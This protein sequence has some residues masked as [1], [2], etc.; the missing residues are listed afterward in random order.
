MQ[1]RYSNSF[2]IIS[3][4]QTVDTKPSRANRQLFDGK[5]AVNP[6]MTLERPPLAIGIGLTGV[7]PMESTQR[8]FAEIGTSKGLLLITILTADVKELIDACRL[9]FPSHSSDAVRK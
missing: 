8:V 1:D 7:A 4:L 2:F 9:P 6:V 5:E 3:L